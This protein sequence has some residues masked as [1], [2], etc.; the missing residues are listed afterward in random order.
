MP[1]KEAT[2]KAGMLSRMMAKALSLYMVGSSYSA[3]ARNN[4]K[5]D[6]GE[7]TY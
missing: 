5:A 1:M 7:R 6:A 2:K 3:D 4:Q